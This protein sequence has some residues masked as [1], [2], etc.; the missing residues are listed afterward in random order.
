MFCPE[1]FCCLIL[2]Y[3]NPVLPWN[4]VLEHQNLVVRLGG[5]NGFFIAWL[6]FLEEF[7]VQW[8]VELRFCKKIYSL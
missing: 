3:S 8:Q 4:F 2:S 6:E 7:F 5:L 1:M